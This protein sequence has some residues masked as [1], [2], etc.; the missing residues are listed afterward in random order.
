MIPPINTATLYKMK[1]GSLVSRTFFIKGT[2]CTPDSAASINTA[3]AALAWPFQVRVLHINYHSFRCA[4]GTK[5]NER[6]IKIM[7]YCK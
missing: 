3:I 6:V 5:I 1:S 4:Q 2:I 7:A